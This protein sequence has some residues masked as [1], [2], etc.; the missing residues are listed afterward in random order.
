MVGSLNTVIE[1]KK[2]SL[3][4]YKYQIYILEKA[5]ADMP[6]VYMT[7]WWQTK[8]PMYTNILRPLDIEIGEENFKIIGQNYG[9]Y[10]KR[11]IA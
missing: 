7:I 1:R 5:D 4:Q 2:I 6:N 11:K 9:Y 3:A 10:K 8:N